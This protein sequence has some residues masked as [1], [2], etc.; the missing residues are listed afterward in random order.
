MTRR[1]KFHNT[2]RTKLKLTVAIVAAMA[3]LFPASSPGGVGKSL[4]LIAKADDERRDGTM[5][6]DIKGK[7]GVVSFSHQKHEALVTPDPNYPHKSMPGVA[8]AGC[9]HN[10]KQVTEAEQ[11]Q[12]C[13]TCHKAEG[14]PDNPEDR[15]GI[16]LNAREIFH[17]SC[18]GCHRA[19]GVRASNERFTNV[20]FT[21]C[22]ECHDRQG[23][24]EPVVAQSESKP[25]V[26][27][28]PE[29]MA[30]ITQQAA[31]EADSPNVDQPLGYAGRSRIDRPE[32][33][34]PGRVPTP[35]RWRLGFPDDPR[36]QK[37]SWL[38]SY[39]QNYLKGDY[40]IIGQHTFLNITAES[41]SLINA[42][43][44]P[45]SIDAQRPST[46]DLFSR[47]EQIAF[48]QNLTLSFDL[49]HGDTAFKPVDW[50]INIAPQININ[51]LHAQRSGIVNVD[52]ARGLART[53]AQVYLQT[54]FS[55][56][57][58]GDT[59]GVFG[60]LRRR[61]GRSKDSPYFDS[62]SVRTGIQPFISD[63]R[64]FIF[65][66]T[67]LGVRLYGNHGNNRYQ[68]NVA[69]FRMLEKDVNSELNT[70][71][72]RNQ[73]VFIANLFRQDTK[74]DGYTAQFSFHYNQDGPDRHF[75]QNG[76]LV[77]PALIEGASPHGV[78]AA[79]F[80][81]AGE[82]HAGR[83]NISHALYQVFGSDSRNPIAGRSVNIN[84]QMAA[85]EA[86]YNQDWLRFKTSFLF[87]SGDSKPLDGTARGFDSILD[88][89]EFAGGRFSFWNNQGIR[90]TRTGVNLVSQN[91]LLPSLR[92]NKFA[93]QGN[94]VN[95]GI[96]IYN[97]GLDA[98][99]TPKIKAIFNLN[100]LHFHHTEPLEAL[101]QK[102][103]VKKEIGLDYGIGMRL[104]PFLSE[105]TVIDAGYASL[106]P[107]AGFK[108]V[109]SPGCASC[110]AEGRILHSVFVRLRVVY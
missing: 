84:A 18:I 91:S 85:A 104:R 75:D 11:F 6:L 82:G 4:P 60:F 94:F 74:W 96:F 25:S 24:Y 77:R 76:F 81:W 97:Y 52:P 109:Y 101:L 10:V 92:S 36:Y 105:N 49:S 27:G 16:D 54:A 33:D 48:R 15:E 87:A 20:S 3:F 98:D 14:D 58:L 40:P 108:Q 78:K 61:S 1:Q 26:N 41:E 110:A 64:G 83:M 35:D 59:P 22:D 62:T 38:N 28:E 66:D 21:R 5:T 89:P 69:W 29:T 51:Y 90:L 34:L 57:R 45:G 72:F 103:G 46:G 55:E 86:S 88:S 100:Y 12:K 50:R 70:F 107:G 63:F 73:S 9:H 7:R 30:A 32:P 79:Y 56:I 93:G 53:E 37:G 65:S 106:V 67:N 80:G 99:L 47:S 8:C 102:S 71:N 13:S 44:L 42:R 31:Q 43:R 95:P 17:R 2:A 23:R 68:F 39:R 19:S